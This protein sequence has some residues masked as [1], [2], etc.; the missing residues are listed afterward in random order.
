M[1]APMDLFPLIAQERR[2]LA[3]LLDTL[4]PSQL[5]TQSLCDAWSVQEVFGHLVVPLTVSTPQFVLAMAR[6]R[7]NFNRANVHLAKK[8]ATQG[9]ARLAQ[10]LRD[11][12]QHRFV[13]P[14][15]SPI[16][17]LTDA[18]VHGQ[19]IRRPLGI[20]HTPQAVPVTAVLDFLVSPAARRG[21]ILRDVTG[22]LRFEASDVSWSHGSGEVVSGPGEALMMALSGRPAA[23]SDLEGAGVATLSGRL[24]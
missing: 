7:G 8:V 5:A 15:G 12:A 10:L 1:L 21:G 2:D 24:R 20:S 23:V 14:G 3:D 4:T 16:N 22:G 11:R 18:L 17:P 13:P 6:A 9:P 19:D